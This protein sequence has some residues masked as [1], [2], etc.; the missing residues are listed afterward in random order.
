MAVQGAGRYRVRWKVAGRLYRRSFTTKTL[1]DAF[2]AQLM[3]AARKGERFSTRTGLPQWLSLHEREV[4]CYEHARQFLVATWPT[5][6]AKSRISFLE[7]L[8]VALP[9]LTRE[10][11]GEPDQGVLRHAL[12]HALNQNPHA[13]PPD[14]AE[15]RA[16]AWLERASL[17]I[18]ALDDPSVVSELLDVLSR[19]LDGTPA[20]PDYYSRRR[21]VMHRVLSYAVRKKRLDVNP[22]GK[23]YLPEGW[24]AR[25]P[26][27]TSST[28]AR[29][30]APTWSRTCSPPPA[31]SAAGKGP[32]SSRS[33]A[34]CSMR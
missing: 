25:P 3:D 32:G 22:L 34:A 11:A 28:P 27:K 21:R 23:A 31:T 5:A 4:S 30:A 33:T 6:A 16:L 18:S 7:T 24:S 15:L 14:D 19:K 2:R 17:P 13:R 29:S 20:A 12:R 26:P 1:A 9:V 10:I 8:S